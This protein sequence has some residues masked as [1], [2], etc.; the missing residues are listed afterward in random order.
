MLQFVSTVEA[1]KKCWAKCYRVGLC[2]LGHITTALSEAGFAKVKRGSLAVHAQMGLNTTVDTMRK[3]DKLSM[4]PSA[5]DADRQLTT[6]PMRTKKQTALANRLGKYV[7]QKAVDVIDPQIKKALNMSYV[8][9][10]R[11]RWHVSYKPQSSAD[12]D[13]DDEDQSSSHNRPWPKFVYIR[14][15]S[16]KD[17]KLFCSCGFTKSMLLPCAHILCVKNG[18]CSESDIHF[19][20]SLLWQAGRIPLSQLSRSYSD[21]GFGVTTEGVEQSELATDA[22]YFYDGY[23]PH[24]IDSGGDF[25]VCDDG[26]DPYPTESG[27]DSNNCHASSAVKVCKH[28]CGSV[29]IK[30]AVFLFRTRRFH[31][32]KY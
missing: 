8:L 6:R 10:G 32:V 25:N 15:V 4:L 14:E 20:Y 5:C 16:V 28:A 24:E 27:V 11:G 21:Q 2:D 29:W 18:A 31:T 22:P 26:Y 23:D 19:R 9:V 1:L 3:Q 12:S 30:C 13:S 17:G 7:T